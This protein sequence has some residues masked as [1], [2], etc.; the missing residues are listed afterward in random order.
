MKKLLEREKRITVTIEIPESLYRRATATGVSLERTI[1]YALR[2]RH[3]VTGPIKVADPAA[4]YARTLI[5]S[6]EYY[7]R[8]KKKGQAPPGGK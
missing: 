5:R 4:V 2:A 3:P 6:R 1:L 7:H 8:R